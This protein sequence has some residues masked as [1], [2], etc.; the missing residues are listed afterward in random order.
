MSI[1]PARSSPSIHKGEGEVAI[2]PG[3]G[4]PRKCWPAHNFIAVIEHLI[5]RNIPV[6][7]LAGP[8]DVERVQDMLKHLSPHLATGMLKVLEN[9]P[10][11]QVADCLQQCKGYL[12]N[13][14]GITHLAA[15]LGVPT[16]ALFGPTDP[17]VWQPPGPSVRVIQQY[18]LEQLPINVAIDAMNSFYL[19]ENIE[20]HRTSGMETLRNIEI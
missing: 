18:P 17:H 10:L 20:N 15:M 1:N 16:L 11:I 3:S 9:V 8:A 13:D 14:S 2:H 19:S 6:L 4:S 7:L 5:Q 12:G